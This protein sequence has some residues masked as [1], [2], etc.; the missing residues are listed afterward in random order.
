MKKVDWKH[1]FR[2]YDLFQMN[3][4]AYI[5][6]LN[7][8]LTKL[9]KYHKI[10]DSGAGSGNLTLGLLKKGHKVSSI[11]FNKF[12]LKILRNKCKEYKNNLVVKFSDV[13]KIFF[14]MNSFDGVASMFVI[15]FVENNQK[16]LSEIYRVLKKKGKFSISA[17]APVKDI[18]YGIIELQRRELESKG[19]L[20]RY[21]KEWKYAMES[22]KDAEKQVLKGN[23]LNILKKLLKET[24]FKKIKVFNKNPYG[25]YAYFITCIK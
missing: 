15:P 12:A 22:A 20:P 21:K 6:T 11:D 7:F 13:Q 23:N 19:L 25:K 24:G 16:Y 5:G 9:K 8:H 1:H 17:W 2:Y 4:E 14:G 3:R 18:H 10:L